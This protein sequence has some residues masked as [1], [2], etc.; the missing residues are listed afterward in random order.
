MARDGLKDG[1]AGEG[2]HQHLEDQAAHASTTDAAA[3][4]HTGGTESSNDDSGGR[5]DRAAAS[6][7]VVGVGV[8]ASE[9]REPGAKSPA[10]RKGSGHWGRGGEVTPGRGGLIK[11]ERADVYRSPGGTEHTPLSCLCRRTMF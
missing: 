2:G 5:A 7:S 4:S 8:G 10:E 9:S 1:K 3:T 11:G 6:W